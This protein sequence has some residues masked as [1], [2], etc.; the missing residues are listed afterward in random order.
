MMFR[1]LLAREP[2]LTSSGT[3][4]QAY[5][6]W[7]PAFEPGGFPSARRGETAPSPRPKR[8]SWPGRVA[9]RREGRLPSPWPILKKRAHFSVRIFV[10]AR[11][12]RPGPPPRGG[13]RSAARLGLSRAGDA[14][15]PL[16]PAITTQRLVQINSR[17]CLP[18][19]QALIALLSWVAFSRAGAERLHLTRQSWRAPGE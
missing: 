16:T 1:P 2:S 14:A 4:T 10:G 9:L 17:R 13:R 15:F 8:R 5:V 19:G 6:R 18:D 7:P 12:R 11:G 3:P